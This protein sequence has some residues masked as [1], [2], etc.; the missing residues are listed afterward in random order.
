MSWG[1]RRSEPNTLFNRHAYDNA[2]QTPDLRQGTPKTGNSIH[3]YPPHSTDSTSHSL[4]KGGSTDA[5]EL[6]IALIND[7]SEPISQIFQGQ[8]ASTVQCS[9]CN[10]TTIKTDNTQDIETDSSTSLEEKLYNFFQPE[11]LEGENAY[12]CDTCKISCRAT[13]TLSYTRTP[14]ILIV[15]LAA[16]QRSPRQV[17]WIPRRRIEGTKKGRTGL[18]GHPTETNPGGLFIA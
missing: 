18:L 7:I 2:R 17:G 12:W 14:T 5:H 1:N 11:T 15:H 8:M 4:Q 3:A 10:N 6:L 9:R 16:E 13:K